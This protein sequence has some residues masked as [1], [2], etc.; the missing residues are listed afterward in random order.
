MVEIGALQ[1][2]LDQLKVLFLV[3]VNCFLGRVI[4]QH[5]EHLGGQE[6]ELLL[7]FEAFLDAEKQFA[8]ILIAESRSLRSTR[9][10]LSMV[11]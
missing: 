10:L 6:V 7:C 11:R 2:V 3:G 1:H 4:H 8:L 5:I 9:S